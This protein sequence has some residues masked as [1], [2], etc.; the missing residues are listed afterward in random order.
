MFTYHCYLCAIKVVLELFQSEDN[1]IGFL[2]DSSIILTLWEFFI[3]K[4]DEFSCSFWD[5]ETPI[6]YDETLPYMINGFWM[7]GEYQMSDLLITCLFVESFV[8]LVG[9]SDFIW[10]TFLGKYDEWTSYVRERRYIGS[11]I[12]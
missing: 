7:S 4:D 12:G 6:S 10:G 5:I 11:V 3:C 9:P 2:F 1:Y 8:T